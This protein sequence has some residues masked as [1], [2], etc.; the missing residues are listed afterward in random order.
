MVEARH[1]LLPTILN[2]RDCGEE[3]T[4]QWLPSGRVLGEQPPPGGVHCSIRAPN[5][6]LPKSAPTIG[7]PFDHIGNRFV[8][9]ALAAT[10]MRPVNLKHVGRRTS[11]METTVDCCACP[12]SHFLVQVSQ[13]P[14]ARMTTV[15]NVILLHVT[16]P[17]CPASLTPSLHSCIQTDPVPHELLLDGVVDK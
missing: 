12:N 10:K 9:T 11:W 13:R 7:I 2:H 17:Y 8:P 15:S 14:P 5:V 16:L 3:V 1:R 6:V 4:S